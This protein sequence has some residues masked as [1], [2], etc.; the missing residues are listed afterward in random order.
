MSSTDKISS[1]DKPEIPGTSL[2]IREL[3]TTVLIKHYGIHEGLFDLLIE[4]H[5]GVGAVGPDPNELSPGAMI[6]ISR[7]GLNPSTNTGPMSIDAAIVNPRK[8]SSG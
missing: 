6:G 1:V 2:S 8:K 5:L 4:F 7:I 3:T